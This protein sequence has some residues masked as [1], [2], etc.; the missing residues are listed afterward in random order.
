M[1]LGVALS[2]GYF[3]NVQMIP[4]GCC[5]FVSMAVMLVVIVSSGLRTVWVAL[6]VMALA[7]V[8]LGRLR[9]LL[10]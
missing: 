10:F 4:P 2:I 9:G 3:R 7:F 8:L 1:M 5:L 6:P